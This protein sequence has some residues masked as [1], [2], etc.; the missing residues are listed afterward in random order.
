[1]CCY[2]DDIVIYG[3]DT[4][5]VWKETVLVLERLCSAGFMIN[6]KKSKFLV[7][8]MKMLGHYIANN[9]YLPVFTQL[10][11]YIKSE[12]APTSV[13][14]VRRLYGLLSCFGQYVPNFSQLTQPI[15]RLMHSKG[16]WFE[17]R[18]MKKHDWIV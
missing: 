1:M 8:S 10:E 14:D 16:E 12:K 13:A 15:A 17:K 5:L 6:V 3:R 2:L 11:A 9:S 4:K 7:S 18:W